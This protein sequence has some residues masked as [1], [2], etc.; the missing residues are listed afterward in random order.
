MDRGQDCVF[1]KGVFITL[2]IFLLMGLSSLP[3]TA[4]ATTRYVA[5]GGSCDGAA[6]CYATIQAAV[7]ASVAGDEIKIAA[8]T[9]A[10]INNQG[11]LAQVV[12]INKSITL[13]GGYTPADW[14]TADP[15][16]NLTTLD[17]Q[18]LG[19]PVAV[20]GPAEVSITG[21]RLTGGNATLLRGIPGNT[22]VNAGGGVYAQSATLTLDRC[23]IFSNTAS[24]EA[25][26]SGY[27]GG[28]FVYGGSLTVT[29]TTIESNL[30][31]PVYYGSGG[32]LYINNSSSVEL[33]GNLI[34]N[35]TGST[36]QLNAGG[37]NGGGIRIE[38]SHVVLT[39]NTITGNSGSTGPGGLASASGGGVYASGGSLT[40]SDNSLSGNTAAKNNYGWGGG[41]A[42]SGCEASLTGNTFE[43][44]QAS[45]SLTSSGSGG[46]LYAYFGSV[47]TLT[48]NLFQNNTA[49][50]GGTGSGGGIYV[51]DS[52]ATLLD[53]TLSGNTGSAGSTGHGGGIF[54]AGSLSDASVFMLHNNAITSNKA[55]SV[56]AGYGGG[57]NAG[58]DSRLTELTMSGNLLQNN[59]AG[60]ATEGLGGGIRLWDTLADLSGNVIVQN[61][62]LSSAAGT[63]NG[64]GLY[65]SGTVLTMQN[66]VVSA[67]HSLTHGAGIYLLAEDAYVYK[68]A[69]L[70]HNTIA[71]NK[72]CGEGIYAYTWVQM[73]LTNSI[74]SGHTAYGAYAATTYTSLVLD[75][76]LWHENSTN[77]GGSGTIITENDYTGDPAFAA[78]L[79]ANYHIA[80]ISAAIDRGINAQVEDDMDGQPRPNGAAPDLG[81]DE[82][83]ASGGPASAELQAFAPQWFFRKDPDTGEIHNILQQRYLLQFLHHDSPGYI[84]T[85]TDWLPDDFAFIAELH[86]PAM[87]FSQVGD[88]LSWQT[89]QVLPP[90]QAAQV[91]LTTASD[92]ITPLSAIVNNAEVSAGLWDFDL[93]ATSQAPLF[94]PLISEPGNG[95]VC[96]GSLEVKGAAFP[97]T[98]V[99]IYENSVLKAT[100][101]ADATGVFSVTY[102]SSAGVG[103][104]IYLTA[105]SCL[106]SAPD[107]CSS[108][109][110]A[111]A[112][113]RPLSFV[114]PQP[115]TMVNTPTS[116]PLVGQTMI[117]RFVNDEGWFVGDGGDFHLVAPHI[118]STVHLYTRSCAEMGAPIDSS[119]SVRLEIKEDNVIV[120]TYFPASIEKP[121]YHFLID[122][123]LADQTRIM[124]FVLSC[125]YEGVENSDRVEG[126][127]IFSSQSS[128]TSGILGTVFDITQGY[129]V[130]DPGAS[131]VEGVSITAMTYQADWGGWVPWPAALYNDQDNPQV[132]GADGQFLFVAPP[133]SYYLEVDGGAD[134]QSWRS[135]VIEIG[136]QPL[137][138]N[139]PLTPKIQG[140]DYTVVLGSYGPAPAILNVCVGDVVRWEV[141]IDPALSLEEQMDLIDNPVFRP[142][143]TGVFDPLLNIL[144]FDG[145]VMLPGNLY[146]RQFTQVGTYVYTDGAGH[147][148]TINVVQRLYLPIIQR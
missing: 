140:A 45:T 58:W 14:N 95:E 120:A 137:S 26:K 125:V 107:Q 124:E 56:A 5:P 102:L 126:E 51:E 16:I 71:D 22:S 52:D 75:S 115:S 54:L 6:P 113:T 38:A 141:E 15:V 12:Y 30:G 81:A 111:I 87:T 35:N 82:Y 68:T 66:N 69:T 64:G 62:A 89:A 117:Y 101:T 11:G 50:S 47:I 98:L 17:A 114:C 118:N 32:G 146:Q 46:G 108:V 29:S 33:T 13:R 31:S 53:N 130:A 94:P 116:G 109:S 88:T 63:G 23:V 3:A 77:T 86:T 99:K 128:V 4:T 24:T 135:P 10:G 27:G 70:L 74:I 36:N 72:G 121:W 25:S 93:Q 106:P 127:M 34:R 43:E 100:T 21:L 60:A 37:G 19:R 78:P 7:D 28:V 67:N 142:L 55:S 119:E 65:G 1:A 136:A 144:G 123:E 40:M 41:V 73:T 49:A 92:L 90:D 80:G 76:T 61:Q 42:L 103:A 132:T 8:G 138:I 139:V 9:Y 148:A 18:G 122:M 57:I 131:G 129:N 48:N 83:Y 145:G 2:V 59:I 20:V 105:V 112:L 91:L 133:G 79:T 147:T 85:L 44:N 134:Y 104:N 110:S 96:P 84:T 39:G 143:S 97:N